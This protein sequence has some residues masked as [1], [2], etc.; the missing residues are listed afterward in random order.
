MCL[1][2]RQAA[3]SRRDGRKVQRLLAELQGIAQGIEA[4]AGSAC[5]NPSTFA[6]DATV[7]NDDSGAIPAQATEGSSTA[8]AS[9][10]TCAAQSSAVACAAVTNSVA[11]QPAP[12]LLADW[13]RA[14]VHDSYYLQTTCRDFLD[15]IGAAPAARTG[16][17][18]GGRAAGRK[19]PR[20]RNSR[21]SKSGKTQEVADKPQEA[22]SRLEEEPMGAAAAL[23]LSASVAAAVVPGSDL[24]IH[25]EVERWS[26]LLQ[27]GAGDEAVREAHGACVAAHTLR[28]GELS[29]QALSEALLARCQ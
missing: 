5:P 23:Q 6:G 17:A 9:A 11:A 28:Y 13:L 26:W 22:G 18:S 21:P 7:S 4:L 10:V 8:L 20:S 2:V 15:A 19:A 14:A 12:A 24:H 29:Q 16:G 25:C 27:S 3:I 1:A